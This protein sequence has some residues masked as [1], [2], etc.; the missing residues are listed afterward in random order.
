L[1]RIKIKIVPLDYQPR[2]SEILALKRY[3][4]TLKRDK[5]YKKGISWFYYLHGVQSNVTKVAIAEYLGNFPLDDL[6]SHGN[7]KTN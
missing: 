4:A 5:N 6:C 1:Q 7:S 2:E 3:Y